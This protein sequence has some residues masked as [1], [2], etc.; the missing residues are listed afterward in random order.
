MARRTV[1]TLSAD[2][3]TV[4]TTTLTT[5]EASGLLKYDWFTI[6]AAL[7]GVVGGTL[8]VYLQRE[9][10]TNVWADWCHFPQFVAGGA[11]VDYTA[12]SGSDKTIHATEI[13]TDAAAGTPALAA[14][15]LV[16]G[17]PGDRLRLVF[18]TGTSTTAPAKT[19]TVYIS[20]WK[21]D[22]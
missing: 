12:Q 8:D 21:A 9:V 15:T 6:D 2:T 5:A 13:S 11:A 3:A 20:G 10:T 17:H 14:N 18:V 19:Q 16:G 1:F 7:T 22:E 4:A